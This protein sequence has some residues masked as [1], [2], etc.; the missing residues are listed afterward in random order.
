MF[1]RMLLLAKSKSGK[2][3][4]ENSLVATRV[5]PYT[6][7]CVRGLSGMSVRELQAIVTFGKRK[8]AAYFVRNICSRQIYFIYWYLR[9]VRSSGWTVIYSEFRA[10]TYLQRHK[11]YKYI[12]ICI[13]IVYR[14]IYI[15]IYFKYV[16]ASLL[17]EY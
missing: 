14:Y 1:V 11:N 3:L 7:A 8:M 5:W 17:S 6:Y 15:Y 9:S 13:Y 4:S 2:N 10:H 16:S 12:Y